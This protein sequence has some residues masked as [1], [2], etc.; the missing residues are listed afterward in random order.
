MKNDKNELIP[1]RNVTCLRMCINYRI[2]NQATRKDHYPLPFMDQML[3]RLAGQA[4][5]CFLDGYSGYNHI[6]VDPTDLEKTTLT[7]PYSV[8]LQKNVIRPVQRTH[9][10]SKVHVCNIL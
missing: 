6:V 4:Y 9:N 1:T 10:F 5:Y 8:C 2:L 3:E 7:C